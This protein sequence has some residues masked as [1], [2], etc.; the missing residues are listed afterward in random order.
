MPPHH[1]PAPR[2]SMTC[3]SGEIV[4]VPKPVCTR[5]FVLMPNGVPVRSRFASFG[6]L[7]QLLVHPHVRCGA[8]SLVAKRSSV[9]SME[10]LPP[11]VLGRLRRTRV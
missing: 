1:P 11:A 9:G 2:M 7:K 3:V 5:L 4:T 8:P 10:K 6:R